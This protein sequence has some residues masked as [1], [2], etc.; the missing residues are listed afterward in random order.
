MKPKR[1]QRRRVKG[2]RLPEGVVCVTRPG[3]YGNP[4]ESA[5]TFR[6]VLSAI[7][8][9]IPESPKIEHY[10]R[11]K[12]IH[13]SL[14]ELRGRDLACFCSLDDECHADVLLEFANR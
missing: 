8:R 11:M 5:K 10:D 6:M 14:G 3:K 13:D 7:D 1:H 2:Y 9:G 12:R 4:Y